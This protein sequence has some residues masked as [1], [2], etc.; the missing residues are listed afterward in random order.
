MVR[1]EAWGLAVVW[2]PLWGLGLQL[3]IYRDVLAA[4]MAAQCMRMNSG[5]A[6]TGSFQCSS[7]RAALCCP[8]RPLGSPK[9]PSPID[10]TTPCPHSDTKAQLLSEAGGR[11]Y[12]GKRAAASLALCQNWLSQIPRKMLLHMKHEN[13]NH[14]QSAL[15]PI[16]MFKQDCF[17]ALAD[18]FHM[19]RSFPWLRLWLLLSTL[20]S[21]CQLI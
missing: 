17:P 12:V 18:G 10:K 9:R 16:H 19:M 11:A 13:A 21:Q 4:G 1:K 14:R 5:L 20:M 6:H 3:L 7:T 8:S 15:L 2:W